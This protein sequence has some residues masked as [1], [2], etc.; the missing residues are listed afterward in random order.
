MDCS[1]ISTF[2][3]VIS[4]LLWIFIFVVACELRSK[5]RRGSVKLNDRLYSGE[6]YN[7]VAVPGSGSTWQHGAQLPRAATSGCAS[8]RR[9]NLAAGGKHKHNR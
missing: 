2:S 5:R 6:Y 4:W 1:S 7:I 3:S 8:G 9:L